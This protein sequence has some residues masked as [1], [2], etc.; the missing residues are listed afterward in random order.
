MLRV[1][2]LPMD[3]FTIGQNAPVF[4]R[5]NYALGRMGHLPFYWSTPDGYPDVKTAWAAS[6]VMLM[7][8]NVGLAMCGVGAGSGMGARMV[9]YW[10][11]RLLHRALLAEDRQQIVGYLTNGGTDGTP[12]AGV[13][14][15]L[16]YAV[17]MIF[18]SPY[19]QWR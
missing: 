1:S 16:P 5:I 8:W 12:F 14:N 6:G 2:G 10:T 4:N 15:R 3:K 9:D 17:A 7:R 13:A 11:E 19:F 18:D